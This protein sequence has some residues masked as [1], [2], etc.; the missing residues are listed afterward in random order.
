M[1]RRS[2][3]SLRVG[4][5]SMVRASSSSKLA[6]VAGPRMKSVIAFAL[7]ASTPG[8][9][10]TSTSLRTRSRRCDAS[11]IDVKPPSDI[12]TTMAAAG[13][14]ASTTAATSRAI[15]VGRDSPGAAATASE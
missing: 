7:A 6:N 15:A 14:S 11:A 10:S 12:P 5:N 9:M 4:L 13:A 2:D 1:P 8:V 3:A